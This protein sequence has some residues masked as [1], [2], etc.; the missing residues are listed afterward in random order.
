MVCGPQS[1]I[2]EPQFIPRGKNAAEGDGWLLALVDNQV[3]NYSD[4]VVL[5][6]LDVE[7]GPIARAHL[8]FRTRN[9][10]HGTWADRSALPA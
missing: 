5:N 8:P 2:Q 4:L 3:T 9:G 7:A 10:L 1:L 6:A